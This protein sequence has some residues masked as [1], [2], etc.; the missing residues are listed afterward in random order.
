MEVIFNTAHSSLSP[1]RA[2]IALLLALRTAILITLGGVYVGAGQGIAG[3]C[4]ALLEKSHNQ[5][6]KCWQDYD[7]LKWRHRSV[8]GHYEQ[9]FRRHY[10]EP[11]PPEVRSR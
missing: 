5:L 11:E 7:D 4:P 1:S 10:Y 2:V 9:V 3:T 6:L 8:L